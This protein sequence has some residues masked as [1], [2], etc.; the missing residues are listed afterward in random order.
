MKLLNLLLSTKVSFLLI[1]VFAVAMGVATF[2]ENDYGT[3]VA[4][5][6]V[7]EAWWFEVILIWLAVNFL[8]HIKKYKLFTAKRWPLGAFHIAFVIMILG[9]GVTRY[10]GNE[11]V[12]HIREGEVKHTFFSAGHFLQ[13]AE[14]D[15]DKNLR[16]DKPMELSSYKFKPQTVVAGLGNR[17][18]NVS[19]EEYLK[20]AH[21]EYVPGKDTLIEVVLAFGGI[22]EDHLLTKGDH[23]PMGK[24]GLSTSSE[25]KGDIRIFKQDS[26][27][28]VQSDKDM[29]IIEMSS[30]RMGMLRVGETLPLQM[31]SLY[32]VDSVAFLV[33]G[34]YEGKEIV[35]HTDDHGGMAT[36]Q[37]DVV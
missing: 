12:I 7:Y 31:R 4:R 1:V 16:Y 5:E 19:L 28:M 3:A 33:K 30:Q 29:H 14:A 26:L 8:S 22:R 24:L 32:Q 15:K 10:F 36:D 13:I 34:V 25:G 20:G 37:T 35:Y 6:A 2:I 17:S 9:A 27:W 11:G 18:F 21:K 23:L